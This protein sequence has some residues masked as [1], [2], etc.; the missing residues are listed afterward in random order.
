MRR[1]RKDFES[2]W[3]AWYP[4]VISFVLVLV[5]LVTPF[6]AGTPHVDKMID[7]S[8]NLASI[9]LGL[10]GALLGIL[11]SI[12]DSSLIAYIF[13]SVHQHTIYR[14]VRH[15]IFGA[16][17]TIAFAAV[18]YVFVGDSSRISTLSQIIFFLWLFFGLFL[19]TSSYRIID[20]LMYLLAN[21]NV[22]PVRPEGTKLSDEEAEAL[23]RKTGR[24]NPESP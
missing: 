19:L 20:I 5:S 12:K 10:L 17:L 24:R 11:I 1:S 6:N 16:F 2:L 15:S 7:A 4:F 13:S 22:L 9:V 3:E 23:K 18:S 21:K 14:Y 8:I